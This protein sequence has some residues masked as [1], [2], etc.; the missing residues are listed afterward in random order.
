MITSTGNGLIQV[1]L[2]QY[3]VNVWSIK[4]KSG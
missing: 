1:N 4:Q 2:L 3:L